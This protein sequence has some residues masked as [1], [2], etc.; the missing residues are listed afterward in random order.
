MTLS[1]EPSYAGMPLA[2]PPWLMPSVPAGK[3]GKPPRGDA[4]PAVK[5]WKVG[6]DSD[7]HT[8]SSRKHKLGG[9]RTSHTGPIK[10]QKLGENLEA[11]IDTA[12]Q[13]LK[14]ASPGDNG[15]DLPTSQAKGRMVQT[16]QD[17]TWSSP[18]QAKASAETVAAS[19]LSSWQQPL[20]PNVDRAQHNRRGPAK[21]AGKQLQAESSRPQKRVQMYE[22]IRASQ[23]CGHCKTCLNRSM[24]KACLTRRAEMDVAKSVVH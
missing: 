5:K 2:L 7:A 14:S 16:E 4:H 8:N 22:S 10:K 13:G 15:P 12:V 23:R 18:S 9:K 20:F 21:K 17:L 19:F 1:K 11:Y 3:P 24:K 6:T